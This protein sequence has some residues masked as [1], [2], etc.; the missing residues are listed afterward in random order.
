MGELKI[1]LTRIMILDDKDR[2]LKKEGEIHFNVRVVI[3][4]DEEAP[5]FLRVPRAGHFKVSDQPGKNVIAL[6]IPVYKGPA[7]R[8][9]RLEVQAVE[10]D[11]ILDD[12]FA[13]Y[14]RSFEGDPAGWAGDYGPQDS[15]A[16]VPEALDD[17][18]LWYRIDFLPSASS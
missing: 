17:W 16:E 2:F 18:R 10:E 1:V 8:A 4:G 11:L 13:K 14:S 5:S 9:L 3:D 7:V 12:Y 6:E 15:E